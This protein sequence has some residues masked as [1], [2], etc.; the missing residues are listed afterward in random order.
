MANQ[1]PLNQIWSTQQIVYLL[2][3]LSGYRLWLWRREGRWRLDTQGRR[4]RSELGSEVAGKKTTRRPGIKQR[5]AQ[6]TPCLTYN[7]VCCAARRGYL[8]IIISVFLLQNRRQQCHPE[9]TRRQWRGWWYGVG[10]YLGGEG[11]GT[12]PDLG[13]PRELG[14]R[15][16]SRTWLWAGVAARRSPRAPPAYLH[17]AGGCSIN[18]CW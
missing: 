6:R 10:Y 11:E 2:V 17:D 18:L 4:R 7:A 16:R 1:P 14:V 3:I 15:Q 5:R 13:S 8:V 12:K 9:A